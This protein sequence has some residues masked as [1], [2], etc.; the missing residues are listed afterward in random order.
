MVKE[1]TQVVQPV[2]RVPEK[3]FGWLGFIALVALTAYIAFFSLFTARDPMFLESIRSNAEEMAQGADVSADQLVQFVEQFT[4][5]SWLLA[6]VLLIP[7]I[8]AFFALIK[9]S[10][11]ILSGIL[12]LVAAIIIAPFVLT[13]FSSLMFVIAAILLFARKD[14]IITQGAT[15][16]YINRRPEYARENYDSNERSVKR[17]HD[18]IE[19]DVESH[20]QKELDRLRNKNQTQYERD[21]ESHNQKELDRLRSKNQTQ[22]ERDIESHNQKE[23]DRVRQ[24]R[25]DYTDLEKTR[26]FSAVDENLTTQ[27]IDYPVTE[28]E[29]NFDIEDAA[30]TRRENVDR[31]NNDDL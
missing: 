2:S 25:D 3:I 21:I 31:R 6:V 12:L 17:H 10:K 29:Y 23:L 20:N 5:N 15:G 11:R 27:E 8:I 22:Y 4:Q 1:Y 28:E 18:E 9:M 30:R 16:E 19:R 26:Q 13:L 14:K 7:I 24:E